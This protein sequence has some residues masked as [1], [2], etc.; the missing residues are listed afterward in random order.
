MGGILRMDDEVESLLAGLH[1]SRKEVRA[2][3]TYRLGQ[4]GIRALP[5]LLKALRDS[6]WVVRYRAVEALTAVADTRVDSELIAALNDER[7]HV[8]YMAAKGLGIR[9]VRSSRVSLSRVLRDENEFV[10]MIAARSLAA[11]GDSAAIPSLRARIRKENVVRV[12]E[13]MQ[14]A[15]DRLENL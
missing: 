6:D 2:E 15:L 11:I 12:I 3:A 13:E 1:A 5:G 4:A 10:R 7:D 14:K 8:R 9:R